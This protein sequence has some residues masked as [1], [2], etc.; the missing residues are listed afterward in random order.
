MNKACFRHNGYS[1]KCS[2]NLL[3]CCSI[4]LLSGIV[5]QASGQST[6]SVSPP[7]GQIENAFIATQ[8]PPASNQRT[9]I[10]L[11]RQDLAANRFLDFGDRAR[12]VK[13]DPDSSI[14]ELSR[15]FHSA[16]DP[17]ISFDAS[18]ILFAGKE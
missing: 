9:G 6:T 8:L 4:I 16:C 2:G 15:D 14:E 3:F 5:T 12:L 10:A 18:H 7:R 17:A 11:E 13:V 1:R